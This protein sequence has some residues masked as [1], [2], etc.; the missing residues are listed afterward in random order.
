MSE[1]KRKKKKKGASG[2]L[3]TRNEL[4]SGKT[5]SRSGKSA[6]LLA[7][8]ERGKKKNKRPTPRREKARDSLPFEV[9]SLHRGR[10]KKARRPRRKRE[11][12]NAPAWGRVSSRSPFDDAGRKKTG[13]SSSSIGAKAEEKGKKQESR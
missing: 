9:D 7:T 11:K 4:G 12:V 5:H 1:G 2:R 8:G 13:E 3:E 10:E 6:V